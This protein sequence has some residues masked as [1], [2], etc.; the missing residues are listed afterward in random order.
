MEAGRQPQRPP[1]S[2]LLERVILTFEGQ[3]QNI[4]R[5]TLTFTA[6]DAS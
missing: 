5:Q 1:A 2:V 4:V 3:L 6:G